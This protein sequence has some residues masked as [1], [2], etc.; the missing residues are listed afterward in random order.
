MNPNY[1]QQREEVLLWM[2]KT[3]NVPEEGHVR[4]ETNDKYF[5]RSG[6]IHKEG[7]PAKISDTLINWLI[8]GKTHNLNG[9]SA[10]TSEGIFVC[11]SYG[12]R[13]SLELPSI[14][15]NGS[16]EWFKEGVRHR[17]GVLPSRI[18]QGE[19]Q[20]FIEGTQLDTVAC[21]NRYAEVRMGCEAGTVPL[22]WINH[23]IVSNEHN[24]FTQVKAFAKENWQDI[25]MGDQDA[26]DVLKSFYK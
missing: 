15:A 24:L 18:F 16:H 8:G 22:E 20:W 21:L 23:I 13:H 3:K 11:T 19:A 4:A 25:G 7:G 10:I 2:E 9:P 17:E 12:L 1:A 26:V 6:L 5:L 14:F